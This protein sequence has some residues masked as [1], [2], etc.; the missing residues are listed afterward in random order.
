MRKMNAGGEHF[1]QADVNERGFTL[2]ELLVVIVVLGV[3]AATVIIALG[4]TVNNAAV[5][6]CN[7]DAKSVE[8]AVEAFHDNP[9]NTADSGSYPNASTGTPSGNDQLTAQASSG[10]GGPYL[11]TWPNSVHYTITLGT[12]GRVFVDGNDYDASATNPCS[13]VS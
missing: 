6:A 8:Q 7:A 13:L 11:R 10:Y 5:T 12:S 9:N 2:I 3:L 1:E 4:S